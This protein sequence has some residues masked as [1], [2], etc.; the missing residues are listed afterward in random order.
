MESAKDPAD[1]GAL[2]FGIVRAMLEM[3]GRCEPSANIAIAEASQAV[4]AIDDGLE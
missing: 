4:V 3:M 1:L 2:L